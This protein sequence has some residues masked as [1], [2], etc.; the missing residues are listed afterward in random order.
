[1]TLGRFPFP[2]SLTPVPWVPH[3]HTHSQVTDL[4]AGER[5]AASEVTAYGPSSGNM[6]KKEMRLPQSV[7]HSQDKEKTNFLSLMRKWAEHSSDLLRSFVC[8]GILP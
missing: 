3:M 2:V 1:M 4:E 5:L 7:T 6:S 8:S